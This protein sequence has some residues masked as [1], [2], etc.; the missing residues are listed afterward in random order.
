[1]RDGQVCKSNGC[2]VTVVSSYEEI[3]CEL[4]ARGDL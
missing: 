1:M 2:E 4:E 3:I